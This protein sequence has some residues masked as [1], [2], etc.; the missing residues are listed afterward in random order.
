MEGYESV[1]F[2]RGEIMLFNKGM[3]FFNEFGLYISGEFGVWL[4][5]CLYMIDKGFIYFIE[6]FESIEKFLG[7]LILL[8]V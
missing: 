1:N 4:E 3:C 7:K 8:V 5:D 6:L 2:V